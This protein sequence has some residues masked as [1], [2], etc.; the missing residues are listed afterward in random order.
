[1][2]NNYI[3]GAILFNSNRSDIGRIIRR[4]TSDA[5]Y[6]SVIEMISSIEGVYG[7]II[8]TVPLSKYKVNFES[9]DYD[10]K[11]SFKIKP[12]TE[13]V[14]FNTIIMYS[15]SA[16][17]YSKQYYIFGVYKNDN[18]TKLEK[19]QYI[20]LPVK[21]KT[22]EQKERYHDTTYINGW[23]FTNN[24]DL[25]VWLKNPDNKKQ[26]Y[27]DDIIYIL[28]E[29]VEVDGK[30]I[31]ADDYICIDSG[32]RYVADT[33][34]RVR[35]KEGL[36]EFVIT[37][38]VERKGVN[39]KSHFEHIGDG[40][41]QRIENANSTIAYIEREL[42]KYEKI[43]EKIKDSLSAAKFNS[44]LKDVDKYDSLTKIKR[45]ELRTKGGK[46]AE[47]VANYHTYKDLL[48]RLDYTKKSIINTQIKLEGLT[49]DN[50][51]FDD[52]GSEED[53]E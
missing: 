27:P 28:E 19:D 35:T 3:I 24:H 31:K 17:S 38:N 9:F 40:L 21:G 6:T 49:R 25:N 4:G 34:T 41:R 32:E 8:K 53:V 30:S 45:N 50:L 7:D 11:I 5:K 26:L 16:A 51:V 47:K 18:I 29:T 12:L 33:E 2:V 15:Y 10:Q 44:F 20:T 1:M 39:L 23:G 37:E 22:P 43:V 52:D 46:Y 48:K 14:E 13:D 36:W 42:P